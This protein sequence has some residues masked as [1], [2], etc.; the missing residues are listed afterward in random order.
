MREV[1][2][3]NGE[4][5]AALGLGTWRMGE[6]AAQHRTEVEALRLALEMGY[7]VIDTAE[8]YGE[9]G[10][11]SV[12]GEALE[13]AQRVGLARESLFIVSKVYP[14]N[15]SAEGI[16]EACER[17]LRRLK[18]DHLDLYLLHWRGAHALAE[19]V[20][21]FERLQRR[22]LIRCWGVSN[23]DLS[24]MLELA[25]VPG[26]AACSVNQ[27]YYSLTQRG[28]EFDLAPWQ[29]VRQVPVMAYSPIDQGVL[30]AHPSLLAL[31]ERHGAT[32]AQLALAWLLA[33]PGTMAIPKAVH[34]VHLRQNLAAA[35][36]KLS[37]DDLAHLDRLFPPPKRKQ[38]LAML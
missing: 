23:F 21:G 38:P 22:G 32:P 2:L 6:Q 4:E 8:M 36:L 14:H 33:Q 11:E 13:Q 17:S 31:A 26:G 1:M 34:A 15:A 27:V 7:R 19:T 9:G 37:P 28:A 25:A 10:A 24:D 30:A 3:P 29:R 16:A 12:L 5:V 18:L 35:D 20:D